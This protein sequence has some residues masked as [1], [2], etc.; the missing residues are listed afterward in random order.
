MLDVRLMAGHIGGDRLP[1]AELCK[2][3]AAKLKRRTR[4]E[5][6]VDRSDGGLACCKGSVVFYRIMGLVFLISVDQLDLDKR[7]IYLLKRFNSP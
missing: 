6:G 4:S 3:Y 5:Q 2:L 1:R 7:T